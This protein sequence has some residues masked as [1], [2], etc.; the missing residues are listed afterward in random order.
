M[1]L[2][3][4]ST[5]LETMCDRDLLVWAASSPSLHFPPFWG[6]A[7]GCSWQHV[8]AYHTSPLL[9]SGAAS[10]TGRTLVLKALSPSMLS[11]GTN[12]PSV[13]AGAVSWGPSVR[14]VSVPSLL[15]SS[16]SPHHQSTGYFL[17]TQTGSSVLMGVGAGVSQIHVISTE[18][19]AA[20]SALPTHSWKPDKPRHPLHPSSIP[21]SLSNSA[22]LG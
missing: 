19:P 13:S 9:T 15:G 11:H 8:A 21:T 12:Y 5:C 10:G 22:A 7:L 18:V 16:L 4:T 6:F 2:A 14:S 1:A 3:F 17:P 20:S